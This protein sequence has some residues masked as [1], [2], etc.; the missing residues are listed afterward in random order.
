M[1]NG[2]LFSFVSAVKTFFFCSSAALAFWGLREGGKMILFFFFFFF[3]NSKQLIHWH[4]M[5][6]SRSVGQSVSSFFFL[7]RRP[8]LSFFFWQSGVSRML[9]PITSSHPY[10]FP[11][12]D[13]FPS[14]LFYFNYSPPLLTKPI[15]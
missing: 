4:L 12:L 1:V 9:L 15:S 7:L 6:F 10:L 11:N 5:A 3:E 2:F 13:L 14:F 8:P